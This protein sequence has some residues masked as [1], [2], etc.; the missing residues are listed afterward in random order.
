MRTTWS[1]FPSPPLIPPIFRRISETTPKSKVSLFSYETTPP[2]QSSQIIYNNKN[3]STEEERQKF[4][5]KIRAKQKTE[6]CKNYSLYGSC[7]HGNNCSFAHGEKELRRATPSFNGYK[8]KICKGFTNETYCIFGSRCNYIHRVSEKR[9]CKYE[10]INQQLAESLYQELIK[11]ENLNKEP[12]I[13]YRVLL[14]K[15]QIVM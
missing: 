3:Y 5:D 7:P 1:Y 4:F 6:L 12:W 9:F 2:S 8:T 11:Y 14:S 13:V 15:Q 10:F